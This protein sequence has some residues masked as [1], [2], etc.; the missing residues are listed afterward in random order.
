[1]KYLDVIYL[2]QK[3]KIMARANSETPARDDDVAIAELLEHY[4]QYIVALAWKSRLREAMPSE[5]LPF[6]IDEL[7]QNVRLKLWQAMQKQSITHIK[8]YIRRIVQN[9]AVN[10]LRQDKPISPLPVNEEGELYQ[11]CL[12]AGPGGNMQ[13]SPD[14][15]EQEEAI[16]DFTNVAA[17]I[18]QKLPP[19]QQRAM[20]CALKDRIDD[21]LPLLKAL[22][23]REID[24][25]NMNWPEE[26]EDVQRL[27]ASLSAVR[28]KLH[29]L[30]DHSEPLN[31]QRTPATQS[32]SALPA[33]Q[34]PSRP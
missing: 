12:V 1:V 17:E 32:N 28:K 22:M 9:E 6:A 5:R 34:Q 31:C 23:D 24:I 7:T 14:E 26:K 11:G 33:H 18:I 13:D 19:R 29:A 4:N 16:A 30:L 27:R 21:T 10:I 3:E 25:G 15:I 2:S 8:A 20:I